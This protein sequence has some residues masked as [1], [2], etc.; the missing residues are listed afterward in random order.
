V[1]LN[2]G[3]SNAQITLDARVQTGTWND[4]LSGDSKALAA[5]TQLEVAPNDV[6][7]FILNEA[8]TDPVLLATLKARMVRE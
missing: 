1:L 6:R 2:K 8:L 5:G 7:V 3:K 4:V